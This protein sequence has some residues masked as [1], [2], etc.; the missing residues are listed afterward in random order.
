ME[1]VSPAV[2]IRNSSRDTWTGQ[3]FG[4]LV[5]RQPHWPKFLPTAAEVLKFCIPVSA[6][7]MALP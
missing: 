4:A 3:Q 1:N 7:L 2:L 5:Y 6:V